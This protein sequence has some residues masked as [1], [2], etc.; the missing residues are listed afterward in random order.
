[1]IP[2]RLYPD[3]RPTSLFGF[4]SATPAH[5]LTRRG[6]AA[7]PEAELS[8]SLRALGVPGDLT[9]RLRRFLAAR[10]PGEQ[11]RIYHGLA[12]TYEV[13]A[14]TARV[15]RERPDLSGGRRVLL[16]LAAAL[17]DVDPSRAPNTPARVAGTLAHLD[18]DSEARTLLEDFG[19]LFRFTAAQLRALILATDYSAD[20]RARRAMSAAFA[21]AAAAA[22]PEETEALEW[23]RMLGYLDRVASYLE[24]D[25]LA[26]RRVAGLARELRG[27]ADRG[28]GPTDEEMLA[29]SAEFLTALGNDPM[30]AQLPSQDRARFSVVAARFRSHNGGLMMKMVRMVCLLAVSVLAAA[31][32]RAAEVREFGAGVI[33]GEPAGATAKLWLDDRLAADLGVGLSDGNAGI[34]GDLLWHDWTLLPQPKDGRLGA[35]VGA[36]P[37]VRAGEDARFGLRAIAGVTYRPSGHPL[38]L[39]VEAGP[40]FRLTQGGQ[41]DAVGGV[42]LRFYGWG[43]KR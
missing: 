36:G 32:A 14:L 25:D 4:R 12:H 35:Y 41:L 13:A 34:W 10:H 9:A 28:S 26:R 27:G 20:P 7:A 5:G 37:Q 18:A 30:F 15:V 17:H 19:G 2:M 43:G 38:E 29:R 22:F 24:S 1:M 33:L 16:I 8:D 23:G 40:L 6:C 31:S 11:D 42:G 21:A 3:A 39:F